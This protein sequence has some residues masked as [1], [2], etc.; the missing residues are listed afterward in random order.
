MASNGQVSDI[1]DT[2]QCVGLFYTK[3]KCYI[4]HKCE[5]PPDGP[6]KNVYTYTYILIHFEGNNSAVQ[7][8][9]NIFMNLIYIKI[10]RTTTIMNVKVK[11][12][13][14]FKGI[15]KILLINLENYATEC[16]ITP[17]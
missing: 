10:S 13:I 12:F 1:L 8:N 9:T 4:L 6:Y 3:M 14:I 17:I 5:F 2:V 7:V 16:S 15:I 11:L